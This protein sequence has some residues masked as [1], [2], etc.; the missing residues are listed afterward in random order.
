M[1]GIDLGRGFCLLLMQPRLGL[2]HQAFQLGHAGVGL[3]ALV[4]GRERVALGTVFL[5]QLLQPGDFGNLR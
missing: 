1:L 4:A 3:L 5:K 2:E